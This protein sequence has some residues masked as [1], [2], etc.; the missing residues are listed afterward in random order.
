MPTIL[1]STTI[2]V[3]LPSTRSFG[4][5]LPLRR[6]RRTCGGGAGGAGGGA[7]IG[8]GGAL[9]GSPDPSP[10]GLAAPSIG[11]GGGGGGGGALIGGPDALPGAAPPPNCCCMVAMSLPTTSLRALGTVGAP[12]CGGGVGSIVHPGIS[13]L[14][15]SAIAPSG[16]CGSPAI[17][18]VPPAC[19]TSPNPD[20]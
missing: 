2:T 19:S 12:A 13:C 15:A 20:R 17:D 18:L 10:V 14:I 9:V 4:S 7:L 16:G 3:R 1:P 6:T 11:S 5:P 8:G